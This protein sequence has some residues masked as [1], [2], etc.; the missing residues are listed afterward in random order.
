MRPARGPT[1]CDAAW[2]FLDAYGLAD[3]RIGTTWFADSADV[4]GPVPATA[5]A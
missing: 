3:D 4:V 1:P 2:R 5:D